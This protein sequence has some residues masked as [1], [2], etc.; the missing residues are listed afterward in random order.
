MPKNSDYNRKETI[1]KI[2]IDEAEFKKKIKNIEGCLNLMQSM[3]D[4]GLNIFRSR[5]FNSVE[6]KY[7]DMVI[8]LEEEEQ[9]KNQKKYLE[10]IDGNH[11][12]NF[13]ETR[14]YNGIKGVKAG[15]NYRVSDY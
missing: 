14:F 13:R 6:E 1:N 2:G 3:K 12:T 10:I 5:L 4:S 11:Q 8:H 15:V 7:L 9:A